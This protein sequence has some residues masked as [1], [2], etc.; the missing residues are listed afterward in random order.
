MIISRREISHFLDHHRVAGHIYDEQ[1]VAA[2][3]Y[4][5]NKQT[6]LNEKFEDMATLNLPDGNISVRP[7]PKF[8]KDW[9]NQ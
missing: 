2:A 1:S 5:A 6:G 9:I 3:K 4:L 7:L 8:R